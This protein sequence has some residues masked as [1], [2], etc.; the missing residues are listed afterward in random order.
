MRDELYIQVE[1][2]QN[3]LVD[4]ATGGKSRITESEFK[5]LRFTLIGNDEIKGMLP[6]FVITNGSIAQFWGYITRSYPSY[7]AR[8]QHIWKGFTPILDY[9]HTRHRGVATGSIT[10][11]I[12]KINQ[13]YISKEWKKALERKSADPEGAITSSRTLIETTCKYILDSKKI[14]YKDDEDLPKL[15]KLTAESLSLAPEQHTEQI[16]KQILGGCQSVVSGLGALRNKIGDAHGKKMTQ[17]QPSSR[18]AE[19]AVNLAG[20]LTTFLLETFESKNGNQI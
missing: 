3:M 2:F 1:T 19:L 6:D 5:Q 12:E 4:L 15:Y 13:E 18:H 7:E 10:E 20:A 9:L 14:E 17:V 8:R 16:F 11:Q